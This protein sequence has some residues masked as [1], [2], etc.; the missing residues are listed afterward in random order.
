MSR[1]QLV[2][3]AVLNGATYLIG[4][5]L[6]PLLPLYFGELG[7]RVADSGLYLSLIFA[8]LMAGA[9]VGGWLSNR[10][11][12]RKA[13]LLGSAVV[14]LAALLLLTLFSSLE[15]L[16]VLA[17]VIWF[18][19]GLTTTSVNILAGLH[20]PAHQRGLVFGAIGVTVGLSQFVGGL[21]A[22]P[23]VSR[24]GFPA[25]FLLV[26]LTQIAPIVAALVIDDSR[27]APQPQPSTSGRR[28]TSEGYWLLLA[29]GFLV[30]V[31]NFTVVLG[32]P[33]AMKSAGL[34]ASAIS[35]T[36]AIAG[37]VALPLPFVMGWLSDRVGRRPLL[38][39][40]W[41]LFASGMF[42]LAFADTLAAF[43][44]SATL[45]AAMTSTLSLSSALV[46]DLVRRSYLSSGLSR[47]SAVPWLGAIV[48]SSAA[49]VVIVVFGL[50][51][52]FLLAGALPVVSALLVLA[53]HQ[54]QPGMLDTLETPAH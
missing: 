3:L 21:I 5:S 19:G 42:L 8:A 24:W 54:P 44:L 17:M 27:K 52:T 53:L 15:A 50:Q 22:G 40:A 4:N 32:R 29:A 45:M 23:V 38:A 26:A 43:W 14:S 7:A 2:A 13:M 46:A 12:Q 33:L 25:L 10:T 35:S 16:I 11:N 48:G 1:K 47:L 36:V 28:S 30:Y 20:A 37:L 51:T 31:V 39:L 18:A 9:L 49:G 34:D 41:A 6:L